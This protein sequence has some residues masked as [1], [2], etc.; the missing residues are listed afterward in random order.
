M[1]KKNSKSASLNNSQSSGLPLKNL[2]ETMA[3]MKKNQ[4][5]ST[6]S[7][8]SIPAQLT[9]TGFKDLHKQRLMDALAHITADVKP[10]PSIQSYRQ[11][12]KPGSRKIIHSQRSIPTGAVRDVKSKTDEKKLHQRLQNYYTYYHRSEEENENHG[13]EPG[14]KDSL[15]QTKSTIDRTPANGNT[16]LLTH[17]LKKVLSSSQAK[18]DHAQAEILREKFKK[19]EDSLSHTKE[20]Q[21]SA[22]KSCFQKL[23]KRVQPVSC[24][25]INFSENDQE[26]NVNVRLDFSFKDLKADEK[27]ISA[28]S[29]EMEEG[30]RLPPSRDMSI[31]KCSIDLD[32]KPYPQCQV[33][34]GGQPSNLSKQLLK[35]KES[36]VDQLKSYQGSLRELENLSVQ[37]S[38]HLL[39]EKVLVN[40]NKRLEEENRRLHSLLKAEKRE[41]E[42]L[43]EEICFLKSSIDSLKQHISSIEADH[44]SSIDQLTS[45]ISSIQSD[46]DDHRHRSTMLFSTI[47]SSTQAL[48]ISNDIIRSIHL[49]IAD[50]DDHRSSIDRLSV[51]LSYIDDILSTAIKSIDIDD[52]RQL[53]WQLRSMRQTMTDMID[54]VKSMIDV[55]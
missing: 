34:A 48:S 18:E 33:N 30:Q 37:N 9:D 7:K 6:S 55:C 20:V 25:V 53:I 12:M 41:K 40:K 44:Q 32:S 43:S 19:L 29:I 39:M 50:I 4:E 8:R 49:S 27:M 45:H 21:P 46:I 42:A 47:S 51:K 5:R 23:R 15:C 16:N 13:E 17:E 10:Q 22:Q 52:S 1:F 24:K 26:K 38:E 2:G 11:V 14:R 31:S 36:S 54:V 28:R 3:H 35:S